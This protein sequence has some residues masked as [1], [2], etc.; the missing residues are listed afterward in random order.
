MFSALVSGDRSKSVSSY[1]QILRS[2]SIVGGA[3]IA[4]YL[5]SLL[6][7]KAVALLLGTQ[8]LGLIGL[9][10]SFT[11]V[12]GTASSLGLSASGVRLIAE[13][14]SSHDLYAV[15]KCRITLQRACWVTGVLGLLLMCLLSP[16]LS[17]AAFQSD[18]NIAQICAL[19]LS[20][21]FSAIAGGQTAIIQGSRRIQ[22]LALLSVASALVGTIVSIAYY[23]VFGEAGIVP[24]IVT[25]SC[26]SVLVG[27]L[28]A[29][30]ISLPSVTHDLL[31]SWNQA[32]GL[33]GLG[34]AIMW[35]GVVGALVAFLTR[36]LIVRNLGLDANGLY[37]AAWGLSGMFVTFVLNAMSA[38]FYPRIAASGHDRTL[39]SRLVNEQ[40]EIG[41][42]LSVP[43]LVA[44]LAFKEVAVTLLY[45]DVFRDSAAL[46]PWL[47]L[48]VFG[49]VVSWPL[50]YTV[51]AL[52]HARQYAIAESF[53]GAMQIALIFLLMHTFG[54]LGVAAAF[55]ALYLLYFIGMKILLS[56]LADV[57]LNKY[58]IRLCI[59]SL[60]F[61]SA[62]SVIQ[63]YTESQWKTVTGLAIVSSAAIYSARGLVMRLG[64]DHRISR[65][66]AHL[67]LIG[68]LTR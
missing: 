40:T 22:D 13:A 58:T 48:G 68:R 62:T 65:F 18:S 47:I 35:S 9:F 33:I 50:G 64:P 10:Q 46:L 59:V 51:M 20:V 29:R 17:Q 60:A 54:L 6:R 4:N 45:S 34:V 55:P 56:R 52:G 49:R 42:L 28:F 32:R 25:S 26:L 44:I 43:G 37:E 2:S 39:V 11:A 1:N 27:W 67:P 14:H 66:I 41:M 19:G 15:A 36:T 38:D 30:R 31:A 61:L 3:Q 21:L 16:I 63:N 8:G 57:R 12:V 53:A 23:S 5:I 7:N 24:A